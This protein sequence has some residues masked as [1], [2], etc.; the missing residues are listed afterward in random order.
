MELRTHTYRIVFFIQP[1]G[2]PYD[3]N[4]DYG[5]CDFGLY[6]KLMFGYCD[7]R[8]IERMIKY[9]LPDIIKSGN[10]EGEYNHEKTIFGPM[11]FTI[12]GLKS[13]VSDN[14]INLELSYYATSGVSPFEVGELLQESINDHL[15]C[16]MSW[17]VAQY[18]DD[19][20]GEKFMHYELDNLDPERRERLM[21]EG[22][23]MYRVFV[24]LF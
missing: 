18:I 8:C 20:N 13:V 14:C 21:N 3:I 17:D 10:F 1:N 22:K 9:D 12:T 23:R 15:D 6:R 4:M 2:S 16:D 19:E 11:K 24:G 7:F 5:S